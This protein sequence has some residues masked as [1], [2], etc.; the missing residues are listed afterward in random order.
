MPEVTF[1][2]RWP[3]GAEE[4]CYSPSTIIRDHLVT[5]QAYTVEQFVALARAGLDQAARRVQA[6]YGMRCSRADAEAAR[7]V[8]T[9]ARYDPKETV[10][11][12]SMT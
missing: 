2:I 5:E 8:G 3:D 9:A 4:T 1:R 12:L 10:Q 7:I 6:L 11:C